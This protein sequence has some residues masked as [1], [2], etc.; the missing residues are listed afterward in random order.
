MADSYAAKDLLTAR[1]LRQVTR[2]HTPPS[3][4]VDVAATG[5]RRGNVHKNESS[6][7]VIGHR[8]HRGDHGEE[9]SGRRNRTQRLHDHGDVLGWTPES[10][11]ATP[12]AQTPK[13]APPRSPSSSRPCS[14]PVFSDS[15]RLRL[16][17]ERLGA[18]TPAREEDLWAG[19]SSSRL[20][21]LENDVYA[22]GHARLRTP[23]RVSHAAQQRR[24][25]SWQDTTGVMPK[26]WSEPTTTRPEAIVLRPKQ[27]PPPPPGPPAE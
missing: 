13:C 1:E 2:S 15:P 11:S 7:D 16:K 6:L 24:G 18:A 25:P 27:S 12:R 20:F 8:S 23:S 21:N 9:S 26:V 22:V 4:S 10:S 19:C 3:P 14:K 17:G 5:V